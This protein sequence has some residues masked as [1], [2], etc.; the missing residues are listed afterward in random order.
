MNMASN[1]GESSSLF[2]SAEELAQSLTIED[3]ANFLESLGVESFQRFPSYLVC[4]TICHN[5]LDELEDAS[6]K[7]YYYDNNKIFYCYTE[8]ATGF[9]IFTLYQKFMELN[10]H[11]VSWGEAVDYVRKFVS[12]DTVAIPQQRKAAILTDFE[13]YRIGKTVIELPQ[14]DKNTLDCFVRY[15]H[16]LWLKEGIGEA[17]MEKF[18]IRFQVRENRIIIPHYDINGRLV[19]IR[20]RAL[21]EE[22]I[23]FGKYRPASIGE[24]IY[25]HELHFNL[26]G[27]Y[28]HKAAIQRYKRAVIVE[29][30]K[31]VLLS[32]TFFGEDSV[33]VAVCG[34]QINKYQIAL[35]TKE[36]GVNEIVVALDKEY[37][38]LKDK[39]CYPYKHKL[40]EICRRYKNSAEFSYIFDDKGLLDYKDSPYD[41]G[42]E[43][44]QTLYKNRKRIK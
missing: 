30:E 43:V 9:T 7:L 24:E 15:N 34:S 31:S 29:A 17:A 16:P 28:E 8:C 2:M 37:T 22:D 12:N 3:V 25:T 5:A 11:E 33:A 18:N 41:K 20:Q 38:D 32:D 1:W 10:Y 23:V 40:I 13:K 14:Y 39:K 35:L 44:F 19:G 4:P 21:E 6:M 26:Y 36:L 42:K 27:I